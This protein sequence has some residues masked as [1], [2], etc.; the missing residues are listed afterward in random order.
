MMPPTDDMQSQIRGS[1]LVWGRKK[2][3]KA[4]A[5]IEK[6][7]VGRVVNPEGLSTLSTVTFSGQA[8][9]LEASKKTDT[10]KGPG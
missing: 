8:G 10:E 5:V 1:D 2:R 6:V 9:R 7:T 3:K 4:V